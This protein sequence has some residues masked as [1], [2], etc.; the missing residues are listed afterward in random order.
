MVLDG[1]LVPPKTWCMPRATCHRPASA[2]V[3]LCERFDAICGDAVRLSD[4]PAIAKV[5]DLL[6]SLA[7]F[8]CVEVDRL[9]SAGHSEAVATVKEGVF[10]SRVLKWYRGNPHVDRLWTKPAGYSGD[11]HTVELICRNERRLTSLTDVFA[12]HLIRCPMAAQH[13]GRVREQARFIEKLIRQR[14]AG[15]PASVLIAGCGPAFDLRVALRR[16]GEEAAANITLVDQDPQALAHCRAK[17]AGAPKSVQFD[18]IRADALEALRLGHAGRFDGILF[19]ALFDYLADKR[20]PC[21]LA[22]CENLLAED[23]SILFSQ[24]SRDNPSRTMMKWFADWDLIER[25]EAELARL[26]SGA[27]IAPARTRVWR[28]PTGCGILCQIGVT[29]GM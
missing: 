13:R 19:G 25:D 22:E 17:L 18:Y 9:E 6:W 15:R 27:G 8:I 10:A 12:N 29:S 14:R 23:G 1:V 24:V 4:A 28:E 5:D 20:I 21:L 2:L 7:N 26:C 3:D 11:D 16:L